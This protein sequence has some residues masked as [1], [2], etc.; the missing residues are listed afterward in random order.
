M[1][2]TGTTL[3]TSHSARGAYSGEAAISRS[4]AATESSSSAPVAWLCESAVLTGVWYC[5]HASMDGVCHASM[6]DHV[7]GVG[8]HTPYMLHNTP[9]TT[10][11]A[12]HQCTQARAISKPPRRCPSLHTPARVMPSLASAAACTACTSLCRSRSANTRGERP[13]FKNTASD[14][15]GSSCPLATR[16]RAGDAMLRNSA[17][18]LILPVAAG[19]SVP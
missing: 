7:A 12:T 6:D 11:H 4:A 19:S 1:S 15:P 3:L 10:L 9:T 16:R 13:L 17:R 5:V 8:C 2:L 14:C 18:H